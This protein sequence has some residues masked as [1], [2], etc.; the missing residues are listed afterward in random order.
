MPSSEEMREVALGVE[1]KA[2]LIIENATKS[3][4]TLPP[5]P[6]SPTPDQ[7]Q[8]RLVDLRARL[9]SV[10]QDVIDAVSLKFRA[11]RVFAASDFNATEAWDK[12]LE[13]VRKA[14]SFQGSE[15]TGPRE[16]YSEANLATFD[17]QRARRFADHAKSFAEEAYT[18]VVAC[19]RG[20]DAARQDC[21]AW[22]RS[23]VFESSLDR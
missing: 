2:Q 6:E 9:D 12:A 11:Q 16:R 17:Q 4:F 15:Y 8:A 13:K 18:V 7:I 23:L 1:K 21:L 22:L 19:Q 10:E 3:R 14:P 20:L 5:F